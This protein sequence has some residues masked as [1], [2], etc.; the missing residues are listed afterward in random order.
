MAGIFAAN[1]F[2]NLLTDCG[3]MRRESLQAMIFRLVKKQLK[4][5]PIRRNYFELHQ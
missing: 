4:Q 5:T 3:Q 2:I 1:I